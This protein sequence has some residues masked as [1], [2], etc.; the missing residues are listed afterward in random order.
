MHFMKL[1]CRPVNTVKLIKIG[2]VS[3]MCSFRGCVCVCG[4]G[5]EVQNFGRD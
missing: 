2:F 4:G 1:S 3:V 5:G